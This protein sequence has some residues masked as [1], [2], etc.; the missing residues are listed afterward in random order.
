M[1]NILTSGIMRYDAVWFGIGVPMLQGYIAVSV[2]VS[3]L[4][5]KAATLSQFI[6][7][8]YSSKLERKERDK[9]ELLQNGGG[10]AVFAV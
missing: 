10:G 9:K 2:T 4:V 8:P 6:Y 1:G 5:I 7:F 3:A